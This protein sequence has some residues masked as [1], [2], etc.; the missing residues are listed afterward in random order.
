V[1]GHA[2]GFSPQQ[3]GQEVFLPAWIATGR[4]VHGPNALNIWPASSWIL[5]MHASDRRSGLPG[6]CTT[7][8]S[9]AGDSASWPFLSGAP[10]GWS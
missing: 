5:S 9:M 1:P 2:D 7:R 6:Y 10:G 4:P 8:T 3:A